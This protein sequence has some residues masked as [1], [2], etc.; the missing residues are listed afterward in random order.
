[1]TAKR[2]KEEQVTSL[3]ELNS[4]VQQQEQRLQ[5]CL[6]YY[7]K[8]EPLLPQMKNYVQDMV[9]KLPVN[10]AKDAVVKLT[11][12]ESK[13]FMKVYRDFVQSCGEL[14]VRKSHRLDI[15]ERQA[16]LTQHN[17]CSAMDSLDPN[18]NNYRAE[19]EEVQT[20]LTAVAGVL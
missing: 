14:A 9:A 1:M 18:L 19:L 4:L 15:L 12:D 11:D 17:L 3:N 5:K 16:R 2:E 20:Q 8:I 13:L 10:E 6:D 7:V